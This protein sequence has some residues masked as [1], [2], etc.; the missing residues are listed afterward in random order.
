MK[1]TEHQKE[2]VDALHEMGLENKMNE[3]QEKLSLL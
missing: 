3:L 2:L 1:L